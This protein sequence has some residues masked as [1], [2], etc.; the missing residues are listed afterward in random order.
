MY[1]VGICISLNQ[2]LRVHVHVCIFIHACSQGRIFET[3]TRNMFEF[4]RVRLCCNDVIVLTKRE[5]CDRL[6][7]VSRWRIV[8]K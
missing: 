8:K 2:L 3:L 5:V 4:S 7:L 1:I 6:R